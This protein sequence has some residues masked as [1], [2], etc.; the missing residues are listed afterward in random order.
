MDGSSAPSCGMWLPGLNPEVGRTC[1]CK[2][3]IGLSN[4]ASDTRSI[5]SQSSLTYAL[6]P[7]AAQHVWLPAVKLSLLC[8]CTGAPRK[9]S[10]QY[11][12][13]MRPLDPS[14]PNGT[15]PSTQG[16][17]GMSGQSTA[18]NGSSSTGNKYDAA[19]RSNGQTSTSYNNDVSI[20]Y[21]NGSSRSNNTSSN[22]TGQAVDRNGNRRT[23]SSP[24]GLVLVRQPVS[25]LTAV[26]TAAG[27]A[28]GSLSISS[29]ER[30]AT[31]VAD[32]TQVSAFASRDLEASAL[33][34]VSST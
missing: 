25:A 16:S 15:G 11:D 33:Q 26:Q 13:V 14:S 7:F 6:I 2:G 29:R 9:T 32:T 27:R 17:N 22:G 4:S 20:S 30:V 10:G 28:A 21:S 34:C 1:T 18:S 12:I 31:Y 3:H 5:A 23:V 8:C 24:N 19:S